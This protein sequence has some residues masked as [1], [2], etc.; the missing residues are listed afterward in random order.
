MKMDKRSSVPLYAQ[1][2]DLLIE[3]VES[4]EYEP[5]S[6]IP[7][8]LQLCEELGLSRPTVRQAISE[9]V[10]EGTLSIVKGRGTFV[11]AAPEKIDIRGFTAFT[12][13]LL[14]AATLDNMH[15]EDYAMDPDAAESL[16]QAFGP[17]PPFGEPG[18][19]RV[20]WTDNAHRRNPLFICHTYISA[21]MFPDLPEDLRARRKMI[22]I[23]ANKYAYLPVKAACRLS[24][25]QASTEEA[26]YLDIPRGAPVLVVAS[27][28]TSRSGNVCEYDVAVLR[29]DVCDILIDSGRS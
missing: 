1:L 16:G 25:R 5:G 17:V 28:L 26:R 23:T 27:R 7:S 9:L 18:M 10:S 15:F 21:A 13:S 11:A 2:K 3:R 4:G 12:F 8:E 20:D 6:R 19:F 14:S 29:S 22:D 24:V